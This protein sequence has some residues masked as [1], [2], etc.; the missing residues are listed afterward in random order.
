[1]FFTAALLAILATSITGDTF[2]RLIPNEYPWD[3]R[4]G[5]VTELSDGSIAT[6]NGVIMEDLQVHIYNSSGE[7]SFIMD[8]LSVPGRALESGGWLVPVADGGFYFVSY[9]EPRATGVDSDIA[10]F[11][12]SGDHEVEWTAITGENTEDVF[13]GFGAAGTPEGGIVL[14]GGAGYAGQDAFLRAYD[15][16]G[17]QTWEHTYLEDDGYLPLAVGQVDDGNLV[18]L[19]HQWQGNTYLQKFDGSGSMEWEL[20][21]P[22]ESGSGPVSFCTMDAGYGVYFSGRE[23]GIRS[24]VTVIANPAGERIGTGVFT[25]G[26]LV[27]DALLAVDHQLILVGSRVIDGV[28]CAVMESYD[29]QGNLTWKRRLQGLEEDGFTG[30]CPCASGGFLLTGYSISEDEGHGS[31]AILVRTDELGCVTGGE[32]PTQIPMPR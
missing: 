6:A 20:V 16:Q 25:H 12:I 23:E 7:L 10:V 28:N 22:F 4:Y 31:G 18:L 3:Y 5:D 9:S 13:T 17:V 8:E 21:I 14:L 26:M 24:G 27:Q 29:Y 2:S 19:S 32:N 30:I 1:M 11:K 15:P